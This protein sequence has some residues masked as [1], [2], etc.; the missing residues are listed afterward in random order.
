MKKS[1]LM[2][3]V[4]LSTNIL[5]SAS[6]HEETMIEETTVM[7]GL[8]TASPTNELS[9]AIWVREPSSFFDAWTS[10]FHVS[11]PEK[12]RGSGNP[13]SRVSLVMEEKNKPVLN[14]PLH[15]TNAMGVCSTEFAIPKEIADKANLVF[16]YGGSLGTVLPDDAPDI[17]TVVLK[18]YID[19]KPYQT[20]IGL[21]R[22]VKDGDFGW[23]LNFL[24]EE[25][26]DNR[27]NDALKSIGRLE[28]Q[29]PSSQE[30]SRDALQYLY[31]YCL[32]YTQLQK[33]SV[34]GG[35]QESKP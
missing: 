30:K 34:I 14:I 28:E 23:R 27:W 1:N 22:S 13:I 33:Q 4:L 11:F 26:N 17:V 12:W 25:L 7:A 3:C 8:Y 9:Y 20:A 19:N 2:L 6:T 35:T 16:H 10:M 24:T 18:E 29:I 31:S 5:V 21:I 32:E 15:F